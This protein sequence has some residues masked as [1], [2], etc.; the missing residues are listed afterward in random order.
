M[1]QGDYILDRRIVSIVA[2]I[3]AAHNYDIHTYS[4]DWVIEITHGDKTGKIFGYKFSLN[5]SA[6]ANIAQDKVASYEI[7]NGHDVPAAA[8]YLLRTKAGLQS[9]DIVGEVVLKP[10]IGTSGHLVQAFSSISE[11]QKYIT[12]SAV[13]A[14]AISPRYEI[15]REM[16]LI[17][18]DDNI[19]LSYEKRHPKLSGNLA[20]F[21]L[22][23][24]AVPRDIEPDPGTVQ[25]AQRAQRAV[26]L[27]V[28]AV[29]IVELSDGTQV[30][31][32]INDGIMMEH[33][34][35]HSPENAAKAHAVYDEIVRR[36]VT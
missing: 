6:S 16:R 18:L 8:H 9:V 26:G 28:C 5:D 13:E 34:S 29:D 27:R 7:L 35:R 23:R 14:W 19:L 32:E 10:L 2:D 4:Y 24:G 1:Q 11:A 31:L 15:A 21:N 36:I 25:L 3:C 30:V 33:Y 17:L 22:G 20:M 12:K